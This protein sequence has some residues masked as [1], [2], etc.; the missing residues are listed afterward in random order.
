GNKYFQVEFALLNYIN[1][2][3]N[4]YSY[5]LEGLEKTWR[6]L[7]TV[8]AV[9]YNNLPAGKYVLH[10]RAVSPS[11]QFSIN[12]IN[13]KI[14]VLQHFY[15]TFWFNMSLIVLIMGFLFLILRA[16]SMQRL[17]LE[18]MRSGISRDLHD[19]VGGV[20]SG[21]A[22]Q[23]ELLEYRSPDHLK[24]FMQRVALS[25]RNA[26]IKMRDVIWAVDTSKDHFEDLL[27]RMKA[28]TL[29]L[30]VPLDISY[31]FV[32]NEIDP[33]KILRAELK[34]NVYL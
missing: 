26:A 22:M 33:Q 30:L 29:E 21:V 10:I 31:K 2:K 4:R 27:D 9:E 12:T 3:S 8:P 15:R 28:F 1:A 17:K 20:L 7:K 25:S 13:L 18:K 5:Y 6:P 23:M 14:F 16:R 32:L 19:E 11:G 24:P 34:Q